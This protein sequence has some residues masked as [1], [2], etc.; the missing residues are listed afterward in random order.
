AGIRLMPLS[1]RR[2]IQLLAPQNNALSDFSLCGVPVLFQVG[3]QSR[4]EMAIGLLTA[5]DCHVAAEQIERLFADPN[6]TPV[7]GSADHARAGKVIDNLRKRLIDF[8]WRN[9]QVTD[10]TAF[11]RVAIESP[12]H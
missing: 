1:C 11:R 5:V 9:D 4:A 3:D 7:T 10:R 12:A 2:G 6:G 8:V